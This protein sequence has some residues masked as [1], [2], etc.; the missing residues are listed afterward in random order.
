[1][2]LETIAIREA[3]PGDIPE[4]SRLISDLAARYI[5]HEFTAQGAE[6]LLSAMNERAVESYFQHGYRYHVAE[7]EGS[8]A[9]VVAT[10]DESHLYHLFV[11]EKYQG[12]G[13]A[14]RLW[15]I[16]RDACLAAHDCC[17][18]TVN[19]SR[20][21]VGFYEKLGFVRQADF[22]DDRGVVSIPMKILL[23]RQ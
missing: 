13:L 19:S 20:Y 3:R 21:A 17:E 7:A 2:M 5:A 10:R 12:R 11:A 8:L 9:G 4:I 15:H 6:Q 14:T 18:F 1:M 22:Q 23:P 16:A